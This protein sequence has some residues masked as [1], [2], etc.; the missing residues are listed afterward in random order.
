MKTIVSLAL[1]FSVL[2]CQKKTTYQG[3]S[4]SN[5]EKSELHRAQSEQAN[6]AQALIE[7]N[8]AHKKEAQKRTEKYNK[9]NQKY[10]NELNKTPSQKRKEEAKQNQ[11]RAPL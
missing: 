1:V 4:I 7:S 6:E 11:H 9:K 10:L 3:A 2:A 5:S 8:R